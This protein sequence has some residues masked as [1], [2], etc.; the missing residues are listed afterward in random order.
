MKASKSYHYGLTET[1]KEVRF[2]KSTSIVRYGD[3]ISLM[4]DAGRIY[5]ATADSFEAA[6]DSPVI[7]SLTMI[8]GEPIK[9]ISIYL[10]LDVKWEDEL[11]GDKE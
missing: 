7:K 1:A 4:G 6:E 3:F 11:K 8:Y 10:K 5:P 2:F 9:V